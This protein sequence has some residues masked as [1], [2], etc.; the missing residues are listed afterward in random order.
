MTSQR[1]N[2][3]VLGIDGMLGSTCYKVL[4]E[5]N[6]FTVKG[7][8]RTQSNQIYFDALG[9]S[10]RELRIEQYDYVLNCIGIIK[11]K[12]TT[13][14]IHSEKEIWKVNYEYPL[15][16]A[17]A[18][19]ESG[20]KMLQIATDCVFSG[21]RGLYVESDVHDATDL[22]GKSKSKGEIQSPAVLNLRTS[23]IGKELG[24]KYSLLNWFISQPKNAS[25]QGF[26]NHYWN[27]VTTTYFAKVV[28]GVIA[29]Q[30][31]EPGT[32]HLVPNNSVTKSELLKLFKKKFSRDDISIVDSEHEESINRTLHTNYP[33]QNENFWKNAGCPQIPSIEE[34]VEQI[35]NT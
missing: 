28:E 34:M 24:S 29:G 19:E 35:E 27:G 15:D 5:N 32:F 4:S 6:N 3:L 13:D 7:T 9:D 22:Y 18:C 23:I 14:L 26:T 16:L 11:Q 33:G 10:P 30:D 1:N 8:S 25:V 2:V 20:T 31:F 12:F 17:S 21:T